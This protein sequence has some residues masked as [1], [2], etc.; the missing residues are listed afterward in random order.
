M[1]GEIFVCDMDAASGMPSNKRPFATLP[2]GQG[3]P[4]GICVDADG[5]LWV[6]VV[7]GG[8]VRRFRS[9][10]EIDSEIKVPSPT[11][12]SVGFGGRDNRTLFITTGTILMDDE[13]LAA[14]P[15]SGSLF[16]IDVPF[17]GLDTSV[18]AG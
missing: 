14:H 16:S 11:V 13:T 4:D 15:L 5:G 9:D 8:A 10:G 18:F 12:T 6:A 1:R 17:Q 2:E 7:T 3:L